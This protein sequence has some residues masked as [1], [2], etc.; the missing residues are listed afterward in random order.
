MIELPPDEGS[1]HSMVIEAELA[2]AIV[3]VCTFPGTVAAKMAVE[4]E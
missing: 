3:G 4:A 1:F 2:E